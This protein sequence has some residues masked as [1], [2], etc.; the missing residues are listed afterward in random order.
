MFLLRT[1]HTTHDELF[2]F[3]TMRG[4]RDEQLSLICNWVNTVSIVPVITEISPTEIRASFINSRHV[5]NDRINNDNDYYMNGVR[6][7]ATS[8][9]GSHADG[10]WIFF[11]LSWFPKPA[12]IPI[13]TWNINKNVIY[14]YL[15][16]GPPNLESVTFHKNPK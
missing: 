14:R 13:T 11:R 16:S 2:T 10:A 7:T 5:T 9:S 8:F 6:Q 3:R 4:P 15:Q 12:A 1:L